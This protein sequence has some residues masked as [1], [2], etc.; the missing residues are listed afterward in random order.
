MA[1]NSAPEWASWNDT[2][3][4]GDPVSVGRIALV[5]AIG[6]LLFGYDTGI[7]AGALL[8]AREDLS[9]GSFE[10]GLVVA[11]VPLGAAFGAVFAGR[12]SDRYGRRAVVGAAAVVFLLGSLACAV[13]PSVAVLAAARFLLGV[14]IGFASASCPVYISEV[15]PPA[16]RGRL[17]SLFQLAVVVGILVAYLVALALEPSEDWRLMLGLGAVPALLLGTGMLQVPP[18]PRW[19]AMVGRDD[20]A[21]AVMASLHMPDDEVDAEL[22]AIHAGLKAE[23]ATW[24]DLVRQPV[25]AALI[26][27]VGLAILQQVTGINTVIYF[28]PTIVEFAGVTS[29]SA[30]IL[31]TVGIGLV[32]LVAT[33][34]A[35]RIVDRAGRRPM[36]IAGISGMVLALLVLALAFGLD[37]DGK[38][39]I[40]APVTVVAL[41]AYVA[42]FALSLGPIFWLLNA[43][44]YPLRERGAAAGAG[45]TANWASNFVV[46]LTFLPL[47][48]ALG[49][50][51]AFGFYAGVG[52]LAVIFC[53]TLVP[54][55]RGRSL[56]E[57]EA[58]WRRR[59]GMDAPS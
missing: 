33:I 50:A 8:F 51:G 44:L 57:I 11:M 41:M 45:T 26:V 38:D 15:A 47:I 21:R 32:N 39:S 2:T 36:L 53:I 24:R 16:H 23:Q 27:G 56:Q 28:A 54:E 35:V 12:I 4:A 5:A 46:S 3:R 43:E 14:A 1:S 25:R 49:V 42:A 37:P 10:Q 31:S 30:A 59:A 52:V 22:T 20:E 9:M 7:I 34:V 18:S 40:T 29:S 48:S 13:A 55:T 58:L 6:G 19:L 17:V